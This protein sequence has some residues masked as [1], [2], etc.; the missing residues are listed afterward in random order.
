[1]PIWSIY[2]NCYWFLCEFRLDIP[3]CDKFTS[4]YRSYIKCFIRL[5][6]LCLSFVCI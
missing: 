6:I 1:M 2:S 3:H 5:T 4:R